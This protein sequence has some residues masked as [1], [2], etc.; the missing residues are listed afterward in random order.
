MTFNATSLRIAGLAA[1][2][3]LS[4]AANAQPVFDT[5]ANGFKG[6]VVARSANPV[7]GSNAEIIGSQFVPGQRVDLLRGQTVLTSAPITVDA[8]GQFKTTL[9]IPA[10]A[11]PGHEH[12]LGGA[13]QVPGADRP[14]QSL[15]EPPGPLVR[16]HVGDEDRRLGRAEGGGELLELRGFF[17]A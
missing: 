9:T 10:D 11:V 4:L 14:P 2:I 17:C 15:A 7:P 3:L 6:K 5:P 16:L 1:S 8:D 12:P 13:H